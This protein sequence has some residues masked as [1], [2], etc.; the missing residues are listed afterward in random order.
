MSE[1]QDDP[2]V[3][4]TPAGALHAYADRAPDE[5]CAA[6]QTLMPRGASLRRSEAPRGISVC[7]AAQVSSGARSAY[8]C[9]APA[10]VSIT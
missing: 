6:L 1:E 3:M 5:T 2:Y 10:G 9:S 8:A 7:S 4:L